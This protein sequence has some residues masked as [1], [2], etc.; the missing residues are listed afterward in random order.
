MSVFW[1]QTKMETK[2]F[3]RQKGALFWNF[4]FPLFFMT[5]FGSIFGSDTGGTR[6]IDFLLPG[7]I[8]M[9]LMTTCIQSTA[10]SVVSDREKGIFRRLALTPLR[11]STLIGSLALTRYLVVLIQTALLML[12]AILFFQARVSGSWFF[13][14]LIL[15]VGMFSLLGIG[16]LIASLVRKEESAQP[17]SMIVF[18]VMMFLSPCFWPINMLPKFL[19]PL[20]RILPATF[21]GQALRK[22]SIEAKGFSSFGSD[23]LFLIVWLV[24]CFAISARYFKWE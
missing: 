22:V 13:F 7:M 8:V 24:V 18:F 19:R 3:L 5:L 17:I 10:I 14:W 1:K 2:L 15:T 9:A 16:F 12:V 6:Y 21:L 4:A 23:L 20:S 11:R